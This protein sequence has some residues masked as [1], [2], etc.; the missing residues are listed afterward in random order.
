MVKKQQLIIKIFL[1]YKDEDRNLTLSFIFILCFAIN[2][3]IYLSETEVK[4]KKQ[5]LKL[6]KS[7]P[8]L[9][10]PFEEYINSLSQEEK[11]DLSKKRK[12]FQK[13]N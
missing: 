8:S 9:K 11:I 10:Q 12:T 4:Y 3:E 13:K 6:F 1:R 7:V 5:H 2:L